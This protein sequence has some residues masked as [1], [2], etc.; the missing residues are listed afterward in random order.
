LQQAAQ[1]AVEPL[2]FLLAGAQA[3]IDGSVIDDFEA[4]A[5]LAD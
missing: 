5:A 4:S 2:W 1:E 3:E